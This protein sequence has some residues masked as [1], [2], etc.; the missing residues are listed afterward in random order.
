MV[1]HNIVSAKTFKDRSKS[2]IASRSTRFDKI[3]TSSQ[4]PIF[5]QNQATK[6]TEIDEKRLRFAELLK[7]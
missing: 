1:L 4:G 2:E 5:S 3:N 7:E 6:I